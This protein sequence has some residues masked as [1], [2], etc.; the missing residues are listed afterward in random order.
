MEI[1]KTK[2][3]EMMPNR[4]LL[5]GSIGF[6]KSTLAASAPNPI[7]INIENRLSE[8]DTNALP[9]PK[10]YDEFYNQ[11]I[12]VYKEEHG[13]K[14]I[15]LDTIDALEALI[16]AK[17]CQ[18]NNVNA[19]S[20]IGYGGGYEQSLVKFKK[21]L[22]ALE[23][24]RQDRKMTVILLAHAH[25]KMIN[26]PLGADYDKYEIKLR[27]K[28]A[29]LIKEKMDLVGLLHTRTYTDTVTKGFGGEKTKASGGQERILSCYTS[30]A[31]DSKNSYNITDDIEIPI[32]NGYQAI[33]DA[34]KAG[35]ESLN[36]IK[37][38]DSSKN[39]K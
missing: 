34:I 37:N 4:V 27:E 7:F 14:C 20:D 15:V 28:N 1:I 13:F 6:G 18:E 10:N 25:V 21:V 9:V 35:R 23:K 24:I 32:V 8:I 12:Q 16:Y 38:D 5:Y 26:N 3:K 2:A 29:A 19:I 31:F 36:N 39:D 30:A 22:D 11:L 33:I 17:V